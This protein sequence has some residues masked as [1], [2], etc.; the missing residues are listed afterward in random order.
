MKHIGFMMHLLIEESNR[1]GKAKEEIEN[2]KK[3][4]K[5]RARKEMAE[6]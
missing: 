6:E 4:D 1:R 5:E 2:K 3:E